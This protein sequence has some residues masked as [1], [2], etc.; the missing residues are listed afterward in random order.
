MR[1]LLPPRREKVQLDVS[2]AIVNIVLLLILF[3]LAT[4]SLLNSPGVGVDLAQ[5]AALPLD[6]LPQP[7]LAVEPSGGLTLDGVAISRDELGAALGTETRLNVL[8]DR[9]APALELIELLSEPE[10]NALDIRLVTIR[11]GAG[12]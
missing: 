11:S 12:P 3:F 7:L 1:S 2:L 10:L 6:T 8:I 9:G 4:G 5:S